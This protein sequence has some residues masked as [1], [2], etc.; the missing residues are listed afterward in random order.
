MITDRP[1]CDNCPHYDP[2]AMSNAFTYDD[3]H[4]EDPAK[5][6]CRRCTSRPHVEPGGR[7][8]DHPWIE[9]ACRD[10][11]N[12]SVEKP[13]WRDEETVDLAGSWRYYVDRFVLLWNVVGGSADVAPE[14]DGKGGAP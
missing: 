7:C 1:C 3:T 10:I 9:A 12:V 4:D 5:G 13:G 8:G 2:E 6:C 11:G 14:A